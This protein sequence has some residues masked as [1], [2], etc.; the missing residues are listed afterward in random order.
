MNVVYS[1]FGLL[2]YFDSKA[3]AK[4]DIIID[5]KTGRKRIQLISLKVKE[6]VR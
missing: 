6:M 4:V 2:E 1:L 5:K 3:F